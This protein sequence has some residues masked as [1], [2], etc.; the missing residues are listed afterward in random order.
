MDY[1]YHNMTRKYTIAFANLF[2]KV[3][4]QHDNGTEDPMVIDVPILYATKSKMF[5]EIKQKT[6]EA[7]KAIVSNYLP[8]MGFVISNMQYDGTRKFNNM[9]PIKISDTES[10]TFTGVPYNYTFDLS[11]LT[12][13]QDDLFQILEQICVMFTPDTTITIKELTGIERDV[14]LN[15]DT[16]SFTSIF[17]YGEDENRTVSCDLSFTL[18]GFLYPRLKVEDGGAVIHK[19]INNL[20]LYPENV[21]GTIVEQSQET[22]DSEI[23]TQITDNW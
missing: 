20:G 17:E 23:I 2:S 1:F 16:T 12:K 13:K 5:Y 21:I 9:I 6:T 18:K 14:S 7:P 22:I 11:I 8:R 4:V 3:K 10:L 15:L 19:I